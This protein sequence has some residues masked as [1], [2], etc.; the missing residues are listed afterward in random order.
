M[1]LPGNPRGFQLEDLQGHYVEY[2]KDQNGS[3][4]LQK[5]LEVADT[6]LI[7][8]VFVE[9]VPVVSDLVI[10]VYGNYVIQ[11]IFDFGT[12]EHKIVLA[13]KLLD[14]IV[15]LSLHLYGCRVIQK[16]LETLPSYIQVGI[17][18]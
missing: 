10:D 17:A 5:E 16:A 13:S 6:D 2:S 18:S 8:L 4:F 15:P 11:K 12:E 9:V 14:D 1:P 7:H 3:R